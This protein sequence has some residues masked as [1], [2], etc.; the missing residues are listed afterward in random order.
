MKVELV[1]PLLP[2]GVEVGDGTVTGRAGWV[3]WSVGRRWAAACLP[4]ALCFIFFLF[5]FFFVE[6]EKERKEG[7]FGV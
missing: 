1:L 6:M 2:F 4:T 3:A 5:F 7:I